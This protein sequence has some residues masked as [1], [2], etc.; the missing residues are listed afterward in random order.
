MNVRN[1]IAAL[2]RRTVSG[3]IR[4]ACVLALLGLAV[5]LLPMLAPGAL[6]VVSSMAV[7]HLVGLSAGALYLVAIFLDVAR[8]RDE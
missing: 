8:R 7:G 2:S 5:M 6:T 3:L 1:L 4:I